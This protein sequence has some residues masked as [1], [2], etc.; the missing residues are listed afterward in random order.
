MNSDPI[1]RSAA[2]I[3]PPLTAHFLGFH[4]ALVFHFLRMALICPGAKGCFEESRV[5]FVL[6]GRGSIKS[7][8]TAEGI[9][10]SA[11][12]PGGC[13]HFL[14]REE[15]VAV[16]RWSNREALVEAV[17]HSGLV[18]LHPP[19]SGSRGSISNLFLS[20]LAASRRSNP[21]LRWRRS[22]PLPGVEI[23]CS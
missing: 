4:S 18:E 3:C 23:A 8:P 13:R 1:C 14:G 5:R 12:V 7:G 16:A 2:G 19:S 11:R 9:C 15:K 21:T 20:F 22:E 10:S 17:R 6:R